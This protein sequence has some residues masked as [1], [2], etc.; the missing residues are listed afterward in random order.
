[1]GYL[2]MNKLFRRL[3]IFVFGKKRLNI[4]LQKGCEGTFD[5]YDHIRVKGIVYKVIYIDGLDDVYFEEIDPNE[6]NY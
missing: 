2:K 5:F 1:M 4:V 3:R 6:D